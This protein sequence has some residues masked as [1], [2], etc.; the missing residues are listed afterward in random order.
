MN[1]IGS[2]QIRHLRGRSR[3]PNKA[4][5]L[6]I[7]SRPREGRIQRQ[8]RRAFIAR[9]RPLTMSELLPWAYPKLDHFKHWHRWSVRR[10]LLRYAVPIGRSTKGRGLPGIW[11]PAA[12]QTDGVKD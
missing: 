4:W 9:A 1:S 10:A 2:A 3:Y 8:I 11:R 7:A 5:A 12:K 6:V